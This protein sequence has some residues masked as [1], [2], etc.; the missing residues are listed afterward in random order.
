[1]KTTQT[2][3]QLKRDLTKG[4]T[5]TM[6]F[7]AMAASSENVKSR[8][9]I[10]RYIIGTQTNG[11]TLS[12]NPESKQGSFLELPVASL[13]E[14]DGETIRIYK[15]NRRPLTPDEQALID[16]MPSHRAENRQ[17]CENDALS[18][19]S[20]TYW[21]DKKYLADNS[22]NWYWDWDKGQRFDSND[23]MM[24]DKKIKGDLDLEYQLI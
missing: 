17:L 20:T 16:N 5:L 18:D 10:P 24:W 2:F 19:G 9:N 6:T 14:Y 11:I 12:P 1:M 15:P 23:M 7:N 13:T 4:R 21:M 22:A 8:L 3:A